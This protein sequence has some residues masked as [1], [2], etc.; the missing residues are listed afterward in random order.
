MKHGLAS[1]ILALLFAADLGAEQS[2]TSVASALPAQ[3]RFVYARTI[4]DKL[5][6]I[7][8]VSR[9]VAS[10]GQSWYELTSHSAEQD[11]LLRLDPAT[12]LASYAEVTNRGKD[13]T[14]KRSTTILENK[15]PT[16][17]DEI[18]VSVMESLVYTLR[19]FP[20]GLRQKARIVFL[21]T[22]AAGNFD[23]DL[24]VTGK[25]TI[26]VGGKGIECWKAQLGLAGI[27]GAFFGK[28]SL[29][30]STAF[31]HYLVKSESAS[32]GPGSPMSVL[33][34]ESYSSESAAD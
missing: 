19:V 8:V 1:V 9:L 32:A 17:P 4:G 23:F 5:D 22:S 34:L 18:S 27:F 10:K 33:T 7:E 24:S 16:G 26:P 3:E 2:A 12:L 21:S 25:E 11:I 29:W 30:Y 20:W 14:L 31:P 13:A 6:R 15:A 28:S